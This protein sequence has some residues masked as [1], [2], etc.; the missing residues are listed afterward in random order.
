[1]KSG[2]KKIGIVVFC[3]FFLKGCLFGAGLVEQE[4]TG[5]YWL[6]ANGYLDEMSIWHFPGNHKS[7]LIVGE[8]VFEVGHNKDF[9]IAKRHPKDST[10]G[11]NKKVTFYHLIKISETGESNDLTYEQYLN[12]RKELNV[13]EEL[14]FDTVFQELK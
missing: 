11:V 8:T 9:I 6:L 14:D 7:N 12:K 13:P 2:L 3:C 1:M 5:D 10:N 4:I